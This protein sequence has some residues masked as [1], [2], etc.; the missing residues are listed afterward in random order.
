MPGSQMWMQCFAGDARIEAATTED[1]AD[2]F[3]AHAEQ[4]HD[5]PYPEEALRNY[6]RNYAEANVRLTGSTER[7]EELGDVTIHPVTEDR[8]DDWI[9]FFDHDAFAGNPDWASCYCLEPH[10][11]A[12]DERPWREVR[13]AMI[14]RLGNG[15]TF[16]YLAYVDGKP[17][18]WVNASLRSDY[19]MYQNVDPEGPAPTSVVGV[20]CFLIAPPYRRHGVSAMLL[21]RVVADAAD[22]GAQWVEG[23][24]HNT[25][26]DD[27]GGHYR[28]P[29]HLYDSRG[30]QPIDERERDTVMRRP[31]TS[32]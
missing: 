26:D 10:V 18:G 19:G 7:L 2:R 29:R 23:Y 16:G 8:I 28:G 14:D 12:D 6:A 1:V 9:E 20:S 17:A 15:G 25:P 32:D 24:P 11:P 22:R 21:D 13:A 30:F 27:D 31:A 4:S 3:V 5:W